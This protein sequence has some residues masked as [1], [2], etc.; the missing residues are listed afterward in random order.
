MAEEAWTLVWEDDFST[1]DRENWGVYNGPGNG[2]T[3][4]RS[5]LNTF[6]QDGNLILRTAPIDGVWHG[7]GVSSRDARAQKYG[8]FVIQARFEAGYGVR[9]VALLWP[10]SGRW[11]PEVDFLEISARDANRTENVI[12]N[13]YRDARGMHQVHHRRVEADFTRWHTI[14]VEWTPT[15]LRYTLD[16]V[17]VA[18]MTE[19]VPREPMWLGL[20]TAQGVLSRDIVPNV[21][22]TTTVD[23]VVDKVEVYIW[24]RRSA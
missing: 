19:H 1:L 8:K 14:A 21:N 12:A 20:Q 22:E 10:S 13:H 24:N 11:P 9:A 3:G 4:P 6:V 2:L 17:T 18:E 7:A 5:R 15:L 16:G 23:F